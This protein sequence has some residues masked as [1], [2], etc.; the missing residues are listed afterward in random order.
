MTKTENSVSIYAGMLE[1]NVEFYKAGWM[2]RKSDKEFTPYSSTAWQQGWDALDNILEG[3]QC[4][5][6][7][8]Q[9]KKSQR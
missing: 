7:K 2:D 1:E 9:A 5:L 8:L 6:A 4:R 3:P